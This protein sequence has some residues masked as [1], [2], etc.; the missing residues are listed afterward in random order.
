MSEAPIDFS[1][2]SRAGVPTRSY[3]AGEIIFREGESG[4]ELYIVQSGRVRIE[5][6]NRVLETLDANSIFGEMALIDAAPRS[7]TAIAA[8]DATVAPIPEK[9]FL[10]LVGEVPF[11]ALKV[12]RVLARR[13]R[14]SNKAW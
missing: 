10:F 1:L 8:T 6:G 4:N 3:K 5:L 14:T 13:L 11:F 2:L 9:Q 12:M 7:A